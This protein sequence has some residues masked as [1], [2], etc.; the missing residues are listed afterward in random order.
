MAP[1]S[2]KVA[3]RFRRFCRAGWA[4]YSSM[5]REVTIGRLATRVADS[6]LAKSA[7]ACCLLA[8]VGTP[9]MAQTDDREARTLPEVEVSLDSLASSLTSVE[10]AAVLTANDF[11]Q[12]SIRS[13]ADLVALL[14]GVDLRTRG[15]NDVQA[16]LSMRGGTFDQMLVLLNGINLTDAQTGHHT[17][18][19]PIDIS[20]VERVELLTPA[21]CMARGLAAFCGAVNIVVSEQYRDRLLADVSLGSHATAKATVLGTRALGRWSLTAAAAYNRSDGYRPNT[22][23]RHGSLFLQGLRHGGR[24]DLHLQLGGQ[25]KDF[26]SA[27]FYSTT[28][29]DQY[30]ATRTLVFSGQ[31]SVVS[32]CRSGIHNRHCEEMTLELANVN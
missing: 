18:D 28:F 31:W 8:A 30:E 15:G 25:F 3:L 32:G 23:Y 20:M 21:Q 5:H 6:S 1:R 29:P 19:I 24:S 2:P 10:P 14:P 12:T 11:R 16:D 27:G 7:V 22:D 26:G 13:I 4:A 17:L 9:T